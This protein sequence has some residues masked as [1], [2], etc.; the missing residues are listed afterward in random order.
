MLLICLTRIRYANANLLFP[1]YRKNGICYLFWKQLRYSMLFQLLF[2]SVMPSY[3]FLGSMDHLFQRYGIIS[4]AS[5][6]DKRFLLGRCIALKNS[7][8]F[9]CGSWLIGFYLIWLCYTVILSQEDW[10]WFFVTI[11]QDHFYLS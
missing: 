5:K 7:V 3:H 8:I 1:N 10:D 4:A 11:P 6:Y 2:Y 9:N